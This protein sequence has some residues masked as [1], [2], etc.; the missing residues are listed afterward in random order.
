MKRFFSHMAL[1]VK[2]SLKDKST[3]FWSF[4]YPILLLS[5]MAVAF[6]GI[7]SEQK[8]IAVAVE[9]GH[10]YADVLRQIDVLD[11]KDAEG[12]EALNCCVTRM[13]TAS[14]GRTACFSCAARE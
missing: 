4:I 1:N 3:L 10:P 8:S 14:I 9:P 11:V 6:S 7:Q 13:S 2:M 5:L 12:D